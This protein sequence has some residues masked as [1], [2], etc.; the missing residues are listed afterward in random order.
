[1]GAKKSADRC[2]NLCEMKFSRGE[3]EITK[4]EHENIERRAMLF[5][6]YAEPRKSIR[7]TM[8]TSFGL[9]H[10]THSAI[11]QNELTLADLLK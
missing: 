2:V 1:L 10:N 9:K 5:M 11:V 7:L 6:Q 4:A 8:V 3:Y